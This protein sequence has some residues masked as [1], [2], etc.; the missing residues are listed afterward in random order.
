[1]ENYFQSSRFIIFVEKIKIKNYCRLDSS[2]PVDFVGLSSVQRSWLQLALN[3]EVK[4][5]PFQLSS[6]DRNSFAGR[7]DLEVFFN[8][9][10]F[11][12]ISFRLIF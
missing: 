3:E 10:M 8:F 6:N 12:L 7:M 1:M 11:L 5:E 9:C 2:V 4:F